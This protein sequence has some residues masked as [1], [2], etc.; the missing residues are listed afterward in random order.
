M[1]IYKLG[2]VGWWAVKESR[3]LAQRRRGEKE[4]VLL[5]QQDDTLHT[6]TYSQWYTEF[7]MTVI[8][9]GCYGKDC[10][11][12][13]SHTHTRVHVHTHTQLAGSEALLH[14]LRWG[15]AFRSWQVDRQ[16]AQAA[17]GDGGSGW[18]DSRCEETV[19]FLW[20]SPWSKSSST[21]DFQKHSW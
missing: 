12:T 7:L 11:V 19:S 13:H 16:I 14:L 5:Y 3:V 4:A 18:G 2:V 9:L 21:S 1:P 15:F 6:S 17:A 20:Y 8:L 10:W